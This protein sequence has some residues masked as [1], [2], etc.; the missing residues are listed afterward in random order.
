MIL[1]ETET[2]QRRLV[3][4]K[5]R[6]FAHS[7]RPKESEYARTQDVI[8]YIG[9]YKTLASLEIDNKSEHIGKAEVRRM[10]D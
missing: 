8:L 5:L 6:L 7:V 4:F 2:L 10:G 9:D 1:I 3:T